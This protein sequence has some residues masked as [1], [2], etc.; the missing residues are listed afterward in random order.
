VGC[1]CEKPETEARGH[2]GNTEEEERPPLG[3]RYQATASEDVTVD[4]SVCVC[5]CMQ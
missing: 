3:G 4:T 1:C 5:V 2:F